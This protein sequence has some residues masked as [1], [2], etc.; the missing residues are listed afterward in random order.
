MVDTHIMLEHIYLVM[1]YQL[2]IHLPPLLQ[3]WGWEGR[4]NSWSVCCIWCLEREYSLP[5]MFPKLPESIGE[6]CSLWLEL[7]RAIYIIKVLHYMSP[8]MPHEVSYTGHLP[9]KVLITWEASISLHI[10]TIYWLLMDL[11]PIF[12]LMMQSWCHSLV[13]LCLTKR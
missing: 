3:T 7:S 13:T 8:N 1:C 12:Q 11:L 6:E 5:A 10:I 4:S 9:A 2:T